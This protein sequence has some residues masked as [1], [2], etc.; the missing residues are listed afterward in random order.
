MK[1]FLGAWAS[2]SAD[3]DRDPNRDGR[4]TAR[5]GLPSSGETLRRARRVPSCSVDSSTFR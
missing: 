1:G 2:F 5:W 3:L 4:R